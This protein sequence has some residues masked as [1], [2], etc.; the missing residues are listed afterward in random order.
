[1]NL[2]FSQLPNLSISLSYVYASPTMRIIHIVATAILVVIVALLVYI[3]HNRTRN[4]KILERVESFR[5]EVFAK[6]THEFRSPVT[7]ILGLSKQLLERKNLDENSATSYLN[8][9]ERQGKNLSELINQLLDITNLR[10][11]QYTL[12]WKTGDVVAFVEMVAESFRVL[13]SQKSIDLFFYSDQDEIV[14]D[15]VPDY[16]KKILYNLLSN[17]IKFSDEGTRVNLFLEADIKAK[18]ARLKVIDQGKGI[19]KKDLPH[20]FQLFY[21]PGTSSMDIQGSGIGLA[22]TKQLIEILQGTIQVESQVGKGTTFTLELPIER[23]SKQLYPYWTTRKQERPPHSENGAQGSPQLIEEVPLGH[24]KQIILLAEDNRDIALYTR[25]IFPEDQ[26][27]IVYATDGEEA[28]KK[29]NEH[30]PDIVITDIIMP[31][32]D[33]IE[34]CK[35]MRSSPL[36]DHVP[37]IIVSAKS[38]D[39]DKL[40]GISSGADAYIKKPFQ[41]DELRI[42]TENLLR[43]R[44][45]LK[46][47]YQ[48][49]LLDGENSTKVE[50]NGNG[51]FVRHVTDIIYREMKNAEFNSTMLAEELAIS[52]SQLNKKLNATTGYPSSSYILQVK[53]D[54]AEKILSTRDKTIGEVAAD[55]GIYDVNYFSRVFKKTTGMTPTQFKKKSRSEIQKI[56]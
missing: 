16:L 9:I 23:N 30:I 5:A 41:P 36:V 17:A 52:I 44:H 49:A 51:E 48:R 11:N 8:A 13:A 45:R 35:K 7:I 25:S 40:E 33:G 19:S 38:S 15:F 55:C 47:K 18:K 1:M 39:A 56:S 24:E 29:A 27:S 32:M 20:I 42:R 2:I 28:L 31:K 3:I 46:E 22:L 21:K 26:Y 43:S 10:S 54:H 53:V 6:I 37:I 34:L 50:V 12:E 4:N 14:T